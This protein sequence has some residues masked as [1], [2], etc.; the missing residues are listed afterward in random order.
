MCPSHCSV[1]FLENRIPDASLWSESAL[2]LALCVCVGAISPCGNRGS[3]AIQART[4]WLT[5]VAVINS[6]ADPE[7]FS[8]GDS[9]DGICEAKAGQVDLVHAILSL[10]AA[11][12]AYSHDLHCHYS[13]IARNLRWGYFA[14]PGHILSRL[15][16]SEFPRKVVKVEGRS[17]GARRFT[18][19]VIR[20]SRAGRAIVLTTHSMEEADLLADRIAIMAAG[21]LVAQGTPLDLKAR[22]GVGYT[23]TVVKQRA[24]ESDR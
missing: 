14:G 7:H 20:R 5:F 13:Y 23:L 15:Y 12:K 9:H 17:R 16:T 21:R 6:R 4:C 19:E 3:V 8:H 1:Q 24:H 2:D 10:Y 18:W 22:Y 11:V